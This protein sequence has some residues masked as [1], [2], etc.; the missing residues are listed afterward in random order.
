MDCGKLAGKTIFLI[1]QLAIGIEHIDMSFRMQEGLVVV[2]AVDVYQTVAD[3][4]QRRHGDT[5][6][7]EVGPVFAIGCYRAFDENPAVFHFKPLALDQLQGFGVGHLQA[8]LDRGRS[9]PGADGVGVGP[10]AKDE[11][12]GREDDGLARSGFSRQDIEAGMKFDRQVFDDGKF[13]DLQFMEHERSGHCAL[14]ESIRSSKSC[15]RSGASDWSGSCALS[16]M[17]WARVFFA[18]A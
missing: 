13:A 17:A 3:L 9:F 11:I 18:S 10:P 14:M 5:A 4:A 6:V 1:R 12:Q 2:L 7:V 15:C 16:I 8:G